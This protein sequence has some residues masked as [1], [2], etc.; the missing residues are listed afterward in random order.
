MSAGGS[1][2]SGDIAAT[3]GAATWHSLDMRLWHVQ[4]CLALVFV[5]ASCAKRS[6]GAAPLATLTLGALTAQL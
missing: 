4:A 3:R 2:T 5:G 6:I 1:R